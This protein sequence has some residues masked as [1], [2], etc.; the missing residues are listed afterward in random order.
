[1]AAEIRVPG[2]KV[3]ETLW[4]SPG[5]LPELVKATVPELIIKFGPSLP[6]TFELPLSP[7]AA[8]FQERAELPPLLRRPFFQTAFQS[9]SLLVHE[10][11][12]RFRIL[13]PHL[14][15]LPDPIE[16]GV[17]SRFRRG[18][19]R[20]ARGAQHKASSRNQIRNSQCFFPGPWVHPIHLPG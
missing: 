17:P 18:L 1:L 4:I 11:L 5:R 12:E 20:P 6:Q 10:G 7:R 15:Q 8:L 13:G 9:R 14:F 16:K 19:F 2:E 3:L